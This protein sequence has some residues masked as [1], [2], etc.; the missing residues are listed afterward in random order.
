MR[1]GFRVFTMESFRNNAGKAVD[2]STEEQKNLWADALEQLRKQE[3]LFGVPS[4]RQASA[5]DG[6]VEAS[7]LD[8]KK[9]ISLSVGPARWVNDTHLHAEVSSGHIGHHKRV[10]GMEEGPLDIAKG[11]AEVEHRVDFFFPTAGSKAV[12]T[13]ETV[14]GYDPSN[15]LKLHLT[16]HLSTVTQKQRAQ[17]EAKREAARESGDKVPKKQVFSYH[18]VRF[19]RVADAEHL[20]ALVSRAESAVAVFAETVPSARGGKAMKK[21]RQLS[22]DLSL[23][24]ERDSAVGL[25]NRW[26]RRMDNEV[27]DDV[28]V[29]L[30]MEEDFNLEHEK[31]VAAGLAFDDVS[32]VIKDAAGKSQIYKPNVLR[33]LFTYPTTSYEPSIHGY[34]SDVL[35]KV[36]SLAA[37]HGIELVIPTLEE[38]GVC[39][40][41]STPDPSSPGSTPA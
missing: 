21:R 27:P 32:I 28:N 3:T 1:Y 19:K 16:T 30:E 33:E 15:L 20:R 17:D 14:A 12:M 36:E 37:N 35:P 38:V 7:E 41:D 13:C 6:A 23:P 24:H 26:Y 34:Y 18:G 2:I 39:L 31:L 10:V 8:A 4:L 25:I 22:L 5:P 9:H 29:V 40:I 11:A